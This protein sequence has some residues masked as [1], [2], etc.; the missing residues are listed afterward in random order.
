MF[1]FCIIELSLSLS[2]ALPVRVRSCVVG[3]RFFLF[4][5][6]PLFFFFDFVSFLCFFSP[7]VSCLKKKKIN[8]K[9]IKKVPGEVWQPFRRKERPAY[10]F[11]MGAGVCQRRV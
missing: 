11:V 9:K 7:Y 10:P 8:K 5:G 4:W 2:L 3:E 1:L 6:F